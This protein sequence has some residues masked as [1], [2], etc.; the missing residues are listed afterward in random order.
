MRAH[1]YWERL[2]ILTDEAS[3]PP[4]YT[5]WYQ[6]EIGRIVASEQGRDREQT[7]EALYKNLERRGYS[8]SFLPKPEPFRI[9]NP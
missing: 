6:D 8:S 4:S 7:I 2:T 1:I 3:L 9:N 5:V